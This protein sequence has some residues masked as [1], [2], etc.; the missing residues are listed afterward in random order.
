MFPT[1]TFKLARIKSIDNKT[2]LRQL[3]QSSQKILFSS[4]TDRLVQIPNF[5]EVFTYRPVLSRVTRKVLSNSKYSL[6]CLYGH[7]V[8]TRTNLIPL[9][10]LRWFTKW[11]E[12]QSLQGT[13]YLLNLKYE[14]DKFWRMGDVNTILQDEQKCIPACHTIKM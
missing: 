13:D 10:I 8:L 4:T 1:K 2:L 3:V 5:G 14:T 6:L 9:K 7:Y 12:A 11:L